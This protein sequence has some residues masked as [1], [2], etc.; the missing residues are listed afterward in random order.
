VETPSTSKSEVVSGLQYLS[1]G[2]KQRATD[3]KA[4]KFEKVKVEKCGS[5]MWTEVHELARLLREGQTKWE[6]LNLDDVDIRL[7]WAGMF[8]RGKRTPQR[9]MMRLKV[10]L[11]QHICNS[12]N[13]MCR[14]EQQQ[15][16]SWAS[17]TGSG[18]ASPLVIGPQGRTSSGKAAAAAREASPAHTTLAAQMPPTM[19]A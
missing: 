17:L 5:N 7:K 4:T 18:S 9:F 6:D 11:L 13:R 12:S 15:H 10:G 8:H 1:E 19:Q 14:T 16:L 3:K 2:A